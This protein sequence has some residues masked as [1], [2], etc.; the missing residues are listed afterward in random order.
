MLVGKEK[1]VEIINHIHD[2]YNL[3]DAF[4]D[5]AVRYNVRDRFDIVAVDGVMLDHLCDVL[6]TAICENDKH[7]SWI[8]WWI[9]ETA[10]G[11]LRDM[12]KIQVPNYSKTGSCEW[13]IADAEILYDFLVNTCR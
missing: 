5:V 4:Y 12:R 9:H 7:N 10:F 1:F 11:R 3:E 13:D 6:E 8:S 2:Q